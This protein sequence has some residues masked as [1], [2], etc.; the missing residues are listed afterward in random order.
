MKKAKVP[1]K[2]RI[3]APGAGVIQ[4]FFCVCEVAFPEVILKYKQ[5]VNQLESD[6]KV[7]LKQEAEEKE[8][9]VYRFCPKV[10]L[11]R[12]FR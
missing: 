1:V 3:V 4:V 10:Y 12:L 11:Y 9:G 2:S 5:K 7:L 6:V 8:V